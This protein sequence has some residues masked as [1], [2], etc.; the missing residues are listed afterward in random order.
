MGAL[1]PTARR[2]LRR[3]RACSRLRGTPR[4][5]S[6]GAGEPEGVTL[7][8]AIKAGRIPRPAELTFGRRDGR[9]LLPHEEVALWREVM[10]HFYGEEKKCPLICK[11]K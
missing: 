10:A 8:E 11:F 1:R 2:A 3:P 6:G 7:I 9:G 5:E 4:D